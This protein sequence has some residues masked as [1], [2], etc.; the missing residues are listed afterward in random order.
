MIAIWNREPA[1][2]TT[3]KETLMPN[4]NRTRPAAQ[5]HV[6]RTRLAGVAGATAAAL[7]V[8]LVARYGAGMQLHTPAFGSTRRPES[9]APGLV[10]ITSAAASLAAWGILS[11]VERTG[12]HPRRAWIATG[13]GVLV[14][15][16]SAPLSGHGVTGTD[17]L[18]LICMHLAVGAVL[19]P[20]F[21]LSIHPGR[22]SADDA[23]T[24]RDGKVPVLDQPARSANA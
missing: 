1:H 7:A 9:I 14:V 2:P 18:A 20:A 17:R 10:A 11:L 8:W 22:R 19:V 5:R 13:L 16:L 3:R 23:T 6:G 12:R 15:S 24:R 4:A 21:A